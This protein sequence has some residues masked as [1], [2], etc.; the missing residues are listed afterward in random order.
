MNVKTHMGHFADKR[1][2]FRNELV[3]LFEGSLSVLSQRR[4]EALAQVG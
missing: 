2:F 3:M 1:P 4:I